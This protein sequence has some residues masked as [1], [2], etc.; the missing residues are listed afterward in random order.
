MFDQGDH[1]DDVA[2]AAMKPA[3][4]SEQSGTHWDLKRQEKDTGQC[5]CINVNT[6]IEL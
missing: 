4:E 6:F 2:N 1:G 5:L 3:C